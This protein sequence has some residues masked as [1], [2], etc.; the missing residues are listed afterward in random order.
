MSIP[1][2]RTLTTG[3]HDAILKTDGIKIVR[4]P[5]GAPQCNAFAERF[6]REAKETLD[7]LI[8][9]GQDHLDHVLRRI[10]AHHNQHRPHQGLDNGIP[11]GYEYPAVPVA[12]HE[13]ECDSSLGGLLRHYHISKAA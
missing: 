5:P 2:A 6:V 4:T 9:L 12:P 7:N 3:G 13:I 11:L 1:E 8:L 10:E